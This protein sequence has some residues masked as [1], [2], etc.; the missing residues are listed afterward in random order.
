VFSVIS[1]IK[2]LIVFRAHERNVYTFYFLFIQ[3]LLTHLFQGCFESSEGLSH[4]KEVLNCL[5]ILIQQWIQSVSLSKGMHWS[6]LD[7]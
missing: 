4:R 2:S 3:I 6:D 5:D 7:R 1:Q